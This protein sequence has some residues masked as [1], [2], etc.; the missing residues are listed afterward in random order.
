MDFSA[1]L[2]I[3]LAAAIGVIVAVASHW[4][5]GIGQRSFAVSLGT[6]FLLSLLLL[7]PWETMAVAEWQF[8]VL[9]LGLIALWAAWGTMVGM[10]V[11][12]L[13]VKVGNLIVRTFRRGK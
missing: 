8:L 12:L 5:S 13:L 6:S 2:I 7:R 10:A 9:S 4:S 11:G 3:P 1:F